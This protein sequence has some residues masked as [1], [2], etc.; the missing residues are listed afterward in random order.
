MVTYSP[1]CRFSI[2]V[3]SGFSRRFPVQDT[4][5]R[6]MSIILE[7]ISFSAYFFQ[8]AAIA[9]RSRYLHAFPQVFISGV[10]GIEDIHVMTMTISSMRMRPFSIHVRFQGRIRTGKRL[11]ECGEKFSQSGTEECPEDFTD[12]PEKIGWRRNY[13]FIANVKC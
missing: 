13:M 1:S 10:R 8:V 5:N 9:S 12:R 4:L 3:Q 6:P 11:G 2:S 7:K